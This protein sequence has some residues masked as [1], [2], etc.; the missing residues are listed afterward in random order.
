MNFVR[1]RLR[2]SVLLVLL[3]ALALLAFQI[4]DLSLLVQQYYSGWIMVF[5]ILM[6]MAFGVKK[7]LSVVPLGSNASWAQ[8]HYYAGQFLVF[9]FFIHIEFS[10]P[11]G[12]VEQALALLLLLTIVVGITGLIISRLY[13]KRLAHL[14]EE[15]IYERIDTLRIEVKRKLE[16]QL[17]ESVERSKSSTLSSYYLEHFASY[18]SKSQDRLAHLF[19]STY[20]HR[21]R[22]ADL[23]QQLRYL[24]KEEADFLSALIYDLKVDGLFSDF[25]DQISEFIKR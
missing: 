23:E 10:L 21:K 14:D 20:P 15:V 9:L 13:A 5:L 12:I 7:R 25:A 4:L 11:N 2:N 1:R 6:L 17:L 8:F 16:L 24:N 3:C 18:F 22:R 19:G